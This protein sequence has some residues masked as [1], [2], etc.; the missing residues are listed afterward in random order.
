[1]A[2]R[3]PFWALSSTAV[4]DTLGTP[5][6]PTTCLTL[7][8]KV[9]QLQH[10][11]DIQLFYSFSGTI[12]GAEVGFVEVVQNDGQ[13]DG[14]NEVVQNESDGQN[15][16]CLCRKAEN[17]VLSLETIRRDFAKWND[18]LKKKMLVKNERHI[19]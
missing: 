1:M 3:S 18:K 8:T 2:H 6:S 19:W 16:T 13:N 15:V 12:F 11:C 7:L 10:Y 17:I 14:Q 9:W 5:C 4:E